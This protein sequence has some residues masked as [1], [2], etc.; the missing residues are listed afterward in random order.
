MTLKEAKQQRLKL[1][2]TGKPCVRG[3][4]AQRYV[5]SAGCSQCLKEDSSKHQKTRFAKYYNLHKHELAIRNQEPSFYAKKM[6]SRAKTRAKKKNLP[7]N[8]DYADVVIPEYCP[9]LNIKLTTKLGRGV[10][11][12]CPSLD[13]INPTLGYVKGNVMVIS[14]LANRIK[15]NANSEQVEAVLFFMRKNDL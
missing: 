5:S 8:I 6:W 2:Y 14:A 10:S 3:H 1:Y 9:I 15:T 7:F 13:K 11:D 4:F 12:N